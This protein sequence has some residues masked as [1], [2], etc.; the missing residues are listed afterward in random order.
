MT[1]TTSPTMANVSKRSIQLHYDL[2][3]AFYRFLWGPHIHHGL[4]AS[5]EEDDPQAAQGKLID[6]LAGLASIQPGSRI[7]DIGC[8]MGGSSIQLAKKYGCDVT[9]ITLSPVQAAWA[10]M[11][12]WSKGISQQVRFNRMDAEQATF[13]DGVFDVL[14]SIEC[15]EHLFD[16]AAFFRRAAHW[17]KPGGRLAICAWLAAEKPRSNEAEELVKQVCEGF[18]CP[19]LGTASEYQTWF[20]D[21]GLTNVAFQDL[22]PRVMQTWEI[23]KRRVKRTGVQYIAPLAGRDMNQFVKDF[24]TILRAYREGAMQYGC[25]LA[26]K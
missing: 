1:A 13:D 21:A 7:L 23:C 26:R 12:A 19:S 16:K 14:W 25:F 4:W 17:L 9:G 20:K 5:T 24:D 2:A 8:G 22:T 18:L 15:T 11:S 10:R 6:H 3:T